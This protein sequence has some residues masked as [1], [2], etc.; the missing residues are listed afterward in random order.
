MLNAFNVLLTQG[1]A[2]NDIANKVGLIGFLGANRRLAQDGQR[3]WPDPSDPTT[4]FPNWDKFFTRDF[5]P[6]I[7]PLVGQDDTSVIVH[8]CAS[9]PLH[10]PVA[11]VQMSH[12][13]M[14]R[15]QRYSLQDMMD[16]HPLALSFAGGTVYHHWH[17]L[18]SGTIKDTTFFGHW[19]DQPDPAGPTWSQPYIA[20]VAA[21]G[22]IF[23]E[24]DNVDIGLVCFIA[25]G[26]T[27]TSGCEITVQK[28]QHM[29][30]GDKMGMFHFGGSS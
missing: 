13:F 21:R 6:N 24:A 12:N 8:A 20:S 27:D 14:G 5:Q 25:I 7:R 3:G 26:M 29:C 19:H 4:Y 10:S 17:A 23:L 15:N 1:P 11:N 9:A 2:W 22:L 30:K 16:Q 28:N 18:V